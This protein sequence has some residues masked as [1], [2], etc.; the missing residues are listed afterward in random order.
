MKKR[1]QLLNLR[2]RLLFLDLKNFAREGTAEQ[3][4]THQVEPITDKFLASRAI[5]GISNGR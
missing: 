5:D 3:M 2:H 4:D 1:K